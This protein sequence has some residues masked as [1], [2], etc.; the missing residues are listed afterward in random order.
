MG[1]DRAIAGHVERLKA[2][3]RRHT[4]RDHV[5]DAGRRDHPVLGAGVQNFTEFPHAIP[6]TTLSFA[7]KPSVAGFEPLFC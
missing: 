1:G 3:R 6:S 7:F 4:Q 5:V 2:Y